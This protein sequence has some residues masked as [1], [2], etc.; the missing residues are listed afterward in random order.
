MVGFMVF[1][2][3]ETVGFGNGGSFQAALFIG[4]PYKNPL[5]SPFVLFRSAGSTG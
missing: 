3:W 5:Q 4:Q 2:K 1:F